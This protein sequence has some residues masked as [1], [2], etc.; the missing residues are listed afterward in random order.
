MTRR[1][2]LAFSLVVLLVMAAV[3]ASGLSTTDAP[4]VEE[5]VGDTSVGAAACPRSNSQGNEEDF[6]VYTWTEM[7]VIQRAGQG[8]IRVSVSFNDGSAQ[9]DVKLRNVSTGATT[10]AVRLTTSQSSTIFSVGC[11]DW[12]V[13]VR[14]GAKLG[15][16]AH[17]SL[18]AAPL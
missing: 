13:M 14:S 16:R 6:N 8:R 17:G 3:S 11:G 4:I 15:S 12:V 10:G 5:G 18:A 2:V 9:A 1:I 7:F